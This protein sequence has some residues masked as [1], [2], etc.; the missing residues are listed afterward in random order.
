[1]AAGR[2]GSQLAG[3]HHDH[4]S[5]RRPA[6]PHIAISAL[7]DKVPT[8][9][10][11][12]NVSWLAPPCRDGA[13]PYIHKVA[14]PIAGDLS[15]VGQHARGAPAA[16]RHGRTTATAAFYAL[17]LGNPA[18]AHEAASPAGRRRQRRRGS[19]VHAREQ[20][21]ARRVE[22]PGARGPVGEV[23]TGGESERELLGGAAA[24]GRGF[25]W[26]A[27]GAWGAGNEAKGG[28]RCEGAGRGA[29]GCREDGNVWGSHGSE[30]TTAV[31]LI[32]MLTR[33]AAHI[34]A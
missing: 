9:Y 24:D 32:C 29:E 23:D 31:A 28:E 11:H 21:V 5:P 14:Q 25:V 19:A 13:P 18:V 22:P 26:R 15:H 17:H 20:D 1:M 33:F 3:P 4:G 34:G 16:A 30:P 2:G 12:N 10:E 8:K 27:W 6:K 7:R